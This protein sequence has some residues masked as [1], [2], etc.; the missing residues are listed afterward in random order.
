MYHVAPLLF[1][2][3]DLRLIL[4]LGFLPLP[5][6]TKTTKHLLPVSDQTHTA[7]KTL[8]GLTE[9]LFKWWVAKWENVG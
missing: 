5:T 6:H 9:S 3:P 2:Q 7:E 1:S 8:D 4:T